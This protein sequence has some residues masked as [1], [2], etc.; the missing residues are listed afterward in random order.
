MFSVSLSNNKSERDILR[1][2]YN[3]IPPEGG[4]KNENANI[5]SQK[6]AW[7]DDEVESGRKLGSDNPRT[8]KFNAGNPEGEKMKILRGLTC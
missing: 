4:D 7:G 3:S 1:I 8:R 2:S 6:T 5:F